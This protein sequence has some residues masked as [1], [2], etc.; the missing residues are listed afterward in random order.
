MSPRLATALA[1]A[2]LVPACAGSTWIPRSRLAGW[3]AVES[4]GARILGDVTPEEMQR[5]AGDLARFDAIF[6]RLI[7]RPAGGATAPLTV[8]LFRSRELAERFGLGRG[9]AGWTHAA[10]DA[11][12]VTVEIASG[13]DEDRNTLLH[14]YTHVLLAQ[15]RRAP[16]PRWV[17]EGLATYF[18]TVGERGGSVVVGAAPGTFAARVLRRGPMPLDR[19]F[20]GSL[21]EM[22]SG[23][24]ADFY[25][26]A[27]ALSH[28]LLSSPAGR[29]EFAA[30][31]RQLELGVPSDE[32]QRLAFGRPMDRLTEDLAVHVGYLARGVPGETVIDA[33]DLPAVA[34]PVVVALDPERAAYELGTLALAL[35]EAE[36]GG[37]RD[38]ALAQNLLALAVAAPG[39]D[40]RTR[41]A[42]A[43]ARAMGGDAD[44]AR[45]AAQAALQ[46]APEDPVV[47]RR[48]ACVALLLAEARGRTPA[49]TAASLTDAEEQY[50]SAL[51]LDPASA[52]AW[53]GLG[54]TYV[55]MGRP[56]DART[57]LEAARSFGWSARLD[58][59]LARLY[60]ERGER[61][62]AAALLRPIA[63]DPHGGHAQQEAAELIERSRL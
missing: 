63:Q 44:G 9:V 11:A 21:M 56:D 10:L 59:D 3:L 29:R 5:L 40:A 43:E 46:L 19:L 14:E 62:R 4:G 25:A 57:A 60:L 35:G 24:V 28:Y 33:D 16:L 1:F 7:G 22:R 13:R 8:H 50:R 2:L 54:R 15:N 53:F 20:T 31:V 61:E 58:V 39:A 38:A 47:R 34:V 18:S 55:R 12:Y 51:A 49:G 48:A 23:E 27:W 45:V 30:F 32:A 26:T 42:F 52:S 6:A 17:D 36:E 37:E 41:A